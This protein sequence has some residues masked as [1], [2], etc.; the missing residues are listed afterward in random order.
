MSSSV[1]V[2]PFGSWASPFRIERL[3]DRVVFLTEATGIDGVCWW[4]EGRPEEAG[5]Q[6][7]V[8]R[9]P[10]GTLTRLTPPGF[11]ARSR[12]HE[13]GGAA[14]LI[15]GEL[16]VVSDFVSGR[17]NRVVAP[18]QL[19]P[20]TPERQWRYADAIHDPA[21]NRLIAVRED[22]EPDTVARHGEWNN[23]LVAIDQAPLEADGRLGPRLHVAGSRTDWISQPRWS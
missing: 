5:I 18:E 16:I 1:T 17:L 8:R 21:H 19:V 22:H 4:L 9:D 3:T 7:L 2:A 11:N 15:D 14:S 10:D 6:V 23:D 13:Y 12:V 20:L